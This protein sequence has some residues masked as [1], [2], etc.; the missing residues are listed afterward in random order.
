MKKLYRIYVTSLT[1]MLMVTFLTT[2]AFAVNDMWTVANSIIVD[3]YGKIAA[4]IA[5]VAPFFTG[6]ATLTP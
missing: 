5:Y 6:L 1:L 2:S 3:V 4:F